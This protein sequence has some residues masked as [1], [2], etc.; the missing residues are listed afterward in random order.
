MKMAP[1]GEGG[2]LAAKSGAAKSGAA[3]SGAAKSGAAKS[4]A[5]KSEA[6]KSVA[7]KQRVVEPEMTSKAAV[8]VILMPFRVM[9][10]LRSFEERS[11][12]PDRSA[13]ST[14]FKKR[15][16]PSKLCPVIKDLLACCEV[17]PGAPGFEVLDCFWAQIS[18]RKG[19]I[20]KIRVPKM[21]ISL[22]VSQ[23]PSG[24]PARRMALTVACILARGFLLV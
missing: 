3:K 9:S 4:G 18:P 16:V 1:I 17:P 7:A 21:R 8:M 15:V 22:S 10:A 13:S 23:A 11:L 2:G 6:V 12:F 24:I 5:A 19:L 14:L 20:I